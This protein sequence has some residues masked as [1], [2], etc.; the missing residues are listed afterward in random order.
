MIHGTITTSLQKVL[1]AGATLLLAACGDLSLGPPVEYVSVELDDVNQ[2]VVARL[3]NCSPLRI[4]RIECS[5]SLYD[6]DGRQLP[7]FGRNYFTTWADVVAEP[8]ALVL[9]E[10]RLASKVGELPPG[11]SI[12]LFFVRKVAFAD[13]STWVGYGG[14]HYRSDQ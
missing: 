2:T 14:Y 6:A 11:A 4:E 9:M 10:T 13:G 7:A 5:F 1:V 8:G 12:G 3:R